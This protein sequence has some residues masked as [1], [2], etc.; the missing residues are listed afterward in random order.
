MLKVKIIMNSVMEEMLSFKCCGL[1]N[2]NLEMHVDNTGDR[3]LTVPGRFNLEN[4]KGKLECSHLFPPWE[5]TIQPGTGVA[6]YCSMD[7]SEWNQ[8]ETLT[9]FDDEGKAYSFSVGDI[10]E[11][12]IPQEE[13]H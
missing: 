3:P 11:Y 1:H 4:E 9:I 8:Y 7:E 5:Q 12:G 2:Q 10:T 6:F 13:K